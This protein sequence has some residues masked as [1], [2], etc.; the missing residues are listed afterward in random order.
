MEDVDDF[1][2][3][4]NGVLVHLVHA[5]PGT[6]KDAWHVQDGD[7]RNICTS[8]TEEKAA[9]VARLVNRRYDEWLRTR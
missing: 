2:P 4:G 1:T 3:C 9:F 8:D 5:A 6:D 7:G